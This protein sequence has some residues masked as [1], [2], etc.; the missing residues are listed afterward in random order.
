MEYGVN[1]NNLHNK[2]TNNRH[3]PK[4]NFVVVVALG[5][6][7]I[8]ADIERDGADNAR[9]EEQDQ[10]KRVEDCQIIIILA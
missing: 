8:S 2:H 1:W 7:D 4:V 6:K 10:Q 9:E 5:L 3:R